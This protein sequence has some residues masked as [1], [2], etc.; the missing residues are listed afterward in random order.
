MIQ[1]PNVRFFSSLGWSLDGAA[2]DVPRRE[3]QPMAIALSAAPD[4]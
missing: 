3:H 4:G 1:L 2:V